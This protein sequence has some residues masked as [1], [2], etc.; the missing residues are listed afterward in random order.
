LS[1]LLS[2]LAAMSM[3]RSS[4]RGEHR[5]ISDSPAKSVSAKL[6]DQPTE[7]AQGGSRVWVS[8]GEDDVAGAVPVEGQGLI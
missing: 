7:R 1:T 6:P 4:M 8:Q 5:S 3:W 2:G